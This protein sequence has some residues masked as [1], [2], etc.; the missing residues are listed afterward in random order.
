M[1]IC[2]WFYG[3]CLQSTSYC[4]YGHNEEFKYFLVSMDG[5]LEMIDIVRTT[6]MQHQDVTVSV[7]D[8]SW[9]C[10]LPLSSIIF[11]ELCQETQNHIQT[12]HWYL[13]THNQ[14][15]NYSDRW[16][17]TNIFNR[18]VRTG[19]CTIHNRQNVRYSR[20]GDGLVLL[21]SIYYIH[22]QSWK[23]KCVPMVKCFS[24][25]MLMTTDLW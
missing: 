22:I 3:A 9:D 13:N 12:Y 2:Y 18:L 24:V 15:I 23:I 10:P 6:H 5:N 14:M 25:T 16:K 20:H 7:V 19:F 17:L 4:M 1:V 21:Y 11:M 8:R